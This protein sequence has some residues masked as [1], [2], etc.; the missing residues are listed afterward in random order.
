MTTPPTDVV[1]TVHNA[2]PHVQACIESLY[3]NTKNFRLIV[4]DDD[5][6]SVTSEWLRGPGALRRQRSNLLI[7]T[8]YPRWWTRASNLGLRLVRTPWAVLLNSDVTLGPGWLEQL[9]QA[10]SEHGAKV[11]LVG[12][13]NRDMTFGLEY[14]EGSWE[15]VEA[16]GYINGHCWLLNMD[17]M[18]E[19]AIQ[20]GHPGW[21]MNELDQRQIHYNAD[22]ETCWALNRLGYATIAVYRETVTHTMNVS[23]AGKPHPFTVELK[24][25]DDNWEP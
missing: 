6:G 5:S 7:R 1:V 19:I 4:V 10:K 25:V 8:N 21:F 3:A 17:A 13:V 9:Y 14:H 15:S 18:A 20:R 2:L 11:G 12:H 22:P 23:I 24:D 16:P